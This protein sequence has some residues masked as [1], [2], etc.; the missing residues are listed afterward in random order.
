M[1]LLLCFILFCFICIIVKIHAST[2]DKLSAVLSQLWLQSQHRLYFLILLF[3]EPCEIRLKRY[4]YNV[5]VYVQIFYMFAQEYTYKKTHPHNR[6]VCKD[7]KFTKQLYIYLHKTICFEY[8]Q[9]TKIFDQI[10]AIFRLKF[11][12]IVAMVQ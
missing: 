2:K 3:C 7:W 5:L 6:Y 10:F 8:V 12:K 4:R 11:L 9:N 1:S